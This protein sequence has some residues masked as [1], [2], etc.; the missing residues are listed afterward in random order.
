MG[1]MKQS[2]MIVAVAALC[3]TTCLGA[4]DLN[5]SWEFRFEEGKTLETSSG[6]DFVATDRMSGLALWHFA[7]AR[8]YHRGGSNIRVKLLAENLA[9]LYDGYRRAKMSTQVVR[10][11]FSRKAAGEQ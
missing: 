9:G 8:T 11:G 7:D 5:G 4:I 3:A 2:C 6:A 1:V 10:E